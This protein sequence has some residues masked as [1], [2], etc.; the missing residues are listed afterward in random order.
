MSSC[1]IC[2]PENWSQLTLI[3]KKALYYNITNQLIA[4]H[5]PFQMK[6]FQDFITFYN[7]ECNISE[8]TKQMESITIA[9]QLKQKQLNNDL[10]PKQIEDNKQ[11]KILSSGTHQMLFTPITDFND[12]SDLLEISKFE[13]IENILR[14]ACMI[15]LSCTPSYKYNSVFSNTVKNIDTL[16]FKKKICSLYIK[17]KV[18]F[19]SD[20]LKKKDESRNNVIHKA[21][22]ALVPSIYSQLSIQYETKQD[23][24]SNKIRDSEIIL[25][26]KHKYL[27]EEKLHLKLNNSE[28][29]AAFN[30]DLYSSFNSLYIDD[31]I[32][33][34]KYL[35]C[36]TY[37]PLK[38]VNIIKSQY[39][40]INID[41]ET[42]IKNSSNHN[43]QLPNDGAY[44]V[45]K[46]KVLGIKGEAMD[47]NKMIAL[48]YSSQ[49]FLKK[50]YKGKY[51][52]WS[53]LSF[54]FILKPKDVLQH[55]CLSK[56]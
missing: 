15:K 22:K 3:N 54:F 30:S 23:S 45:I 53:E 47:N 41:I 10:H 44:V 26:K 29:I 40:Q 17:D 16:N 31:P 38:M 55:L 37:D 43:S 32:V 48:Q 14:Q 12:L 9:N 6:C 36:L 49:R 35:S 19:T 51:E 46:S 27:S 28:T 18:I 8:I 56:I 7:L 42:S 33:V 20:P 39:Q 11:D 13:T 2:L 34:D 50:L 5:P 24:Q 1:R 4:F 52:K 25:G 21:L